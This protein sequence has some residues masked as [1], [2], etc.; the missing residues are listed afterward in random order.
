MVSSAATTIAQYLAS[1]PADRRGAIE[2]VRDTVNA[3]LPAGYQEG[4]QYGMIGWCI[5]LSRYADT[6]NGQP[7]CLAALAAQKGSNSLYLMTVYGDKTVEKRFRAGFKAA[8][9]KLDMGKSCV[10]FKTAEALALDVIGDT[11]SAV[12]VDRYI[13]HYEKARAKTK[14]AKAKPK[15]PAASKPAK[16]R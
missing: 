15:K 11:I 8:G 13:A 5:P 4:M 7:L 12:S 10:R 3:H 9:K 16:R 1:L 2:R 6:H 14:S